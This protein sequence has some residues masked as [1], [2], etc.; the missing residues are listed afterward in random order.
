LPLKK[1]VD[2]KIEV[3]SRLEPP[4]KVPYWLNQVELMELKKKLNDLLA[5]VYV[6]P[7]KSPYGASVLFVYKK[8]GKLQMC[9]DYKALNKVTIKNNYPLP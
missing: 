2:H 4:S 5:R 7:S 8:D 1:E 6:R 9:I 3:I